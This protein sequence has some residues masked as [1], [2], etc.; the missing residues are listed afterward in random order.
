MTTSP[1]DRSGYLLFNDFQDP[2]KT[3]RKAVKGTATAEA[4]LM[5]FQETGLFNNILIDEIE[6][7]KRNQGSMIPFA[8]WNTILEIP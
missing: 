7:C 1:L 4:R 6:K 2:D 3:F 8:F 5:R